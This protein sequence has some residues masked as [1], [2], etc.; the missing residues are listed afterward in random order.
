VMFFLA[1][2]QHA[3]SSSRSF[4]CDMLQSV[5]V[6]CFLVC[7]LDMLRSDNL[8]SPYI[9]VDRRVVSFFLF[10]ALWLQN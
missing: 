6:G 10:L 7:M 4:A 8:L 2:I 5:V 9:S 1:R 3:S